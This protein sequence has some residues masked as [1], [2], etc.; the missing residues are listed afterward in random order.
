MNQCATLRVK[1]KAVWGFS[2]FVLS[3]AVLTLFSTGVT[4][5]PKH[6]D[7][8]GAKARAGVPSARV[9]A[10]KM[11][12]QVTDRS[13]R[14]NPSRTSSV[15]VTLVPGA[16]LPAEFKKFARGGKLDIISGQVLDLPNRVLKQ[17]AKYP[18]VFRVHDNRAIGK[19]NYRTS[20][21][22]GAATV[23]QTL[24]YTGAGIGV[25]VIDSGIAAWHDDLTKV[26][27]STVYPYGN[28]RVTTFVDFVNGHRCRTTTTATGATSPAS[29]WATATTRMG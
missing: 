8:Q 24:G 9:K 4:A 22:I 16:N 26:N 12:D 2:P 29:S 27:S 6:H 20:V 10:Y 25:A 5:A 14:G 21:T 3:L 17:L 7:R 11:D 19:E 13:N 18:E 1:R 28:Q 23:W 15:I